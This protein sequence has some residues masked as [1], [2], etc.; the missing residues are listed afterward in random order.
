MKL[1]PFYSSI[2]V[3]SFLLALLPGSH[4]RLLQDDEVEEDRRYSGGRIEIPEERLPCPCCEA[5]DKAVALIMKAQDSCTTLLT[6]TGIPAAPLPIGPLD[7]LTVGCLINSCTAE[8]SAKELIDAACG[9]PGSGFPGGIPGFPRPIFPRGEEDEKA[10][11][12]EAEAERR[13][14]VIIVPGMEQSYCNVLERLFDTLV[15]EVP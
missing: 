14:P 1:S 11:A 13:P 2:L 15:P 10:E 3:L 9:L 6:P 7:S 4:A 5:T 12:E 8:K